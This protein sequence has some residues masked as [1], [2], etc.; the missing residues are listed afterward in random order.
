MK[1]IILLF[2]LIIPMMAN[3]MKIDTDE[4]DEF[5]GNRTVI[6][7]WESLCSQKIHI[8]FR[9]QNGHKLLDFKLFYDGAIV[10]GKDEKLMLKST[11]DKIGEFKSI[12]SY[13][14]EKGGGAIGFAGS[15]AWGIM[16]T[17]NGDLS[18]FSNNVTRLMR[19]YTTD[20]Y[21]DKKISEG[22]G[23][24]LIDLYNLFT[25]TI[26]GEVGKKQFF[27]YSLTFVKRKVNS[28]G[29]WDTVKEDYKKNLSKEEL[30]TIVNEWKTLSDEKF[31]YDVIIK[32]DK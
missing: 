20:K 25:S 15:A 4:I 10:I 8:R 5:T 7:S 3:A 31:E 28:K 6:T 9:M 19:I 12:A 17:Y 22:D 23:K 29:S 27:N 30:M 18:Y 32:K 2:A 14:G 21:I 26:N 24:K 16:A 11:E 1:K 13:V